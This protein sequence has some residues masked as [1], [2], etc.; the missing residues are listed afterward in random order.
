MIFDV[1]HTS[2]N[3]FEVRQHC[4]PVVQIEADT[5]EDAVVQAGQLCVI[6]DDGLEIDCD[7]VASELAEIVEHYQQCNEE[8]RRQIAVVARMAATTFPADSNLVM[9][10]R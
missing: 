1:F 6:T 7:S 9:F 5:E 2:G 4:E 10:R 8:G 3:T